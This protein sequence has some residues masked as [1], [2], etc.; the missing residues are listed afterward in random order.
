VDANQTTYEL[1]SELTR[2]SLPSARRDPNQKLAWVNSICLLF[3]SI[4][5]FGASEG[6][7]SIKPVPPIH[8]IVPVVLQPTVLPPQ[9]TVE[10]KKPVVENNQPRVV[11][12]LP[13]APNIRFSVP[14][15]GTLVAPAALA[16]APPLNPLQTKSQIGN[17]DN[18]G[19]SGDRPKPPYP[20][21]AVQHEEQGSIVLLL[22][23]DVAGNVVSV[24]VK[25]SS[26]FPYL[27]QAAVAFVKNHWHLPVNN[28]SRLFE[29]KLTYL[30]Q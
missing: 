6:V 18:T 10:E 30:L 14:T 23:S 1:K 5:I 13:S 26:G 22:G 20:P 16:S 9:K 27:D 29:T 7:I 15:I 12:A 28:G 17:I 24:D 2:Y 25:E 21:L 19:G 4:G 11:V 3:L 8:Q